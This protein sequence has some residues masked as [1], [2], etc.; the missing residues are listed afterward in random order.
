MSRENM[1]YW[2]SDR[3]YTPEQINSI[4]LERKKTFNPEEV[5]NAAAHAMN[6]PITHLEEPI[7]QGSVNLVC[8]FTTKSGRE[9]VIRVH[10]PQVKNEYFFSETEAMRAAATVGVPVPEII[11]VDDTRKYAPFDYMVMTRVPGEVMR[12]A[13]ER[14][15]TLHPSYLKQIGRYL[16]MLHSLSTTGYGFFDNDQAKK[17]TLAGIDSKNEE[18]FLAALDLDKKFHSENPGNFDAKSI[19]LALKILEE[20]SSIAKCDNPTLIHNDIADWNTVVLG[21]N[22]TGILDWDECFSGDPVFEFAT[23]SL[24]YPDEKMTFIKDGYKEVRPLPADYDDKFDLYVLRYII[25]KSKIAITKIKYAEK[26][27]MR[28]WL[29]NANAKLANSNGK[30]AKIVAKYS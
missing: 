21:D 20:N 14:D 19:E 25:N 17:G 22:V 4:F 29:A 9:G 5:K 15:P 6:E 7:N 16:G 26:T 10:P 2:Q 28:E 3:P 27:S 30:I 24:F 18:H 23:L 8:P 12:P 11:L 13:V 1:F